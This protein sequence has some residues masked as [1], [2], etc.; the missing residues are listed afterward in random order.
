MKALVKTRKDITIKLAKAVMIL[1]FLIYAIYSVIYAIQVKG[2]VRCFGV[3]FLYQ[4]GFAQEHQKANMLLFVG[5]IIIS[6]ASYLI[7]AFK[8]TPRVIA[9]R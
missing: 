9:I 2:N 3:S 5:F 6:V 8:D 4:E 7:I 1:A